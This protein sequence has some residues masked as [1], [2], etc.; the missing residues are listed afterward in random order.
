[1]KL[2]SRGKPVITGSVERLVSEMVPQAG[3]FPGYLVFI[4]LPELI[5]TY[6]AQ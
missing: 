6:N 4:R 3:T 5:A 1:V 2:G